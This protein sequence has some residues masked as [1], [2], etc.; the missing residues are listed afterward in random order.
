MAE[1]K[2]LTTIVIIWKVKKQRHNK[3]VATI[4]K[5]I[6]PKCMAYFTRDGKELVI[7]TQVSNTLVTSSIRFDEKGFV[8]IGATSTHFMLNTIK[9][10]LGS[11]ISID[12]DSLKSAKALIEDTSTSQVS[13]ISSVTHQLR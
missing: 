6:P 11:K 3:L 4:N 2:P 8:S 5:N 9:D 1:R 12:L 10:S 13:D 7:V